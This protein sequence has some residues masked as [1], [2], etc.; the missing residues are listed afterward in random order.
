MRQ[1]PARHRLF[2]TSTDQNLMTLLKHPIKRKMT[3]KRKSVALSNTLK[4]FHRS[5]ERIIQ[6]SNSFTPTKELD[7]RM[8]ARENHRKILSKSP[9]LLIS[10]QKL[11]PTRE[12]ERDDFI[13]TADVMLNQLIRKL[14][15]LK[16]IKDR[17]KEEIEDIHIKINEEKIKGRRASEK[18]PKVIKKIEKEKALQ[19]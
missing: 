10:R 15:K 13:D 16:N 18:I 5:P 6:L 4:S 19:E 8:T 3:K 11:S 1:S 14:S 12:I 2:E 9:S 7:S 17:K